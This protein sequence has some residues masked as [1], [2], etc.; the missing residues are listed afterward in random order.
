M[1]KSFL[2]FRLYEILTTYSVIWFRRRETYSCEG[3]A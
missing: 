3:I 1:L 2:Y